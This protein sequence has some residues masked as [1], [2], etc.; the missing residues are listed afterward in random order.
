MTSQPELKQLGS[1][2]SARAQLTLRQAQEARS[3][4]ESMRSGL[5]GRPT[6]S[7]PIIPI[8]GRPAYEGKG[9]QPAK[10]SGSIGHAL[11]TIEERRA[12]ESTLQTTLLPQHP[13]RQSSLPRKTPDKSWFSGGPGRRGRYPLF[14]TPS[15]N[16]KPEGELEDEILGLYTA[17][18]SNPSLVPRDKS[19][20]LL[21]RRF[22]IANLLHPS[23]RLHL[24]GGD[25]GVDC[26]DDSAKQNDQSPP[27]D[28]PMPAH[29]ITTFTTT[30]NPRRHSS[31]VR[32]S[33][34]FLTHPIQRL[35]DSERPWKLICR[36]SGGRL[37][38]ARESEAQQSL[39]DAKQSPAGVNAGAKL[40]G[41]KEDW[42][43][44]QAEAEVVGDW[45]VLGPRKVFRV[46]VADPAAA[47][48]DGESEEDKA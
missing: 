27:T 8:G 9:K 4:P 20:G 39:V 46:A 16:T 32:N 34:A 25:L 18:Q 22:S 5:A 11:D 12:T 47:D 6:I 29:T 15:S 30:T 40:D 48:D 14:G 41:R 10:A 24:R 33:G 17:L 35:A 28:S 45:G 2:R 36:L 44:V 38:L 23:P 42:E 1:V 13:P 3:K 31:S 26:R 19:Q 37:E 43:A 7:Y 21:Q